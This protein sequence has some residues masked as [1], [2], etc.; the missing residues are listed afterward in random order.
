MQVQRFTYEF[1]FRS[2]VYPLDLAVVP[3]MEYVWLEEA[4]GK[5]T[6]VLARSF[7]IGGVIGLIAY[8][9]LALRR[10]GEHAA[11]DWQKLGTVNVGETSTELRLRRIPVTPPRDDDGA[12]GEGEGPD[13][14]EG[15]G[16]PSPRTPTASTTEGPTAPATGG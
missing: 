10:A 4:T 2:K 1:T 15:A 9:M 5:P 16:T 12:D 8:L 7:D 11:A 6:V 3:A 14:S 13:P